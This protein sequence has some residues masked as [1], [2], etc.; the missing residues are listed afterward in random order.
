[1]E[2]TE[3]NKPSNPGEALA[4]RVRVINTATG[5]IF[6]ALLKLN[7]QAG[8][9]ALP[10]PALSAMENALTL[11]NCGVIALT[12]IADAQQ[13]MVALAERD[14]AAEIA[15]AVDEAAELKATVKMAETT[16]RSFIG[17]P[18]NSG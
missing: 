6:D 8:D 11:I 14:I 4:N 1:M 15:S 9:D 7:H 12:E 18:K 10:A 3:T 17:Q 13:R 5:G 2:A 16:K